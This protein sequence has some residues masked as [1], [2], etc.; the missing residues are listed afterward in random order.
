M[1]RP[2]GERAASGS[3]RSRTAA[4]HPR[5]HGSRTAPRRL[6]KQSTGKPYREGL[7]HSDCEASR[8]HRR[9]RRCTRRGLPSAAPAA[10][11]YSVPRW[12]STAPRSDRPRT[13]H[14]LSY[15]TSNTEALVSARGRASRYTY[16]SP[17][18]RVLRRH[19]KTHFR[20]DD[21]GLDQDVYCMVHPGQPEPSCALLR[22]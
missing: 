12:H 13:E 10:G 7:E 19:G 11:G 4:R 21:S 14:T 16:L 9:A 17:A 22:R 20:L 3:S 6:R 5:D 18:R 8:R 15:T 2:G 1:Q